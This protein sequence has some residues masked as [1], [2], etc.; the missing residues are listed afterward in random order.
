MRSQHLQ[1]TTYLISLFPRR[2]C[3]DNYDDNNEVVEMIKELTADPLPY[4]SGQW[5]GDAAA[6]FARL[7]STSNAE[8]VS[9]IPSRANEK[10]Q[11]NMTVAATA[12]N[13]EYGNA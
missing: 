4:S 3:D 7:E 9:T 12:T 2:D 6:I 5:Q 11:G 10:E 13:Q 1:H 8:E